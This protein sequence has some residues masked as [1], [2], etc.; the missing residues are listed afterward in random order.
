MALRKKFSKEYL[1]NGFV[2]KIE[3]QQGIW[4]PPNGGD[5]RCIGGM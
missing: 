1:L 2:P 4:G 5:F 3:A